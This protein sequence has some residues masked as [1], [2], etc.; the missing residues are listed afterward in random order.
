VE[1]LLDTVD[2]D[3]GMILFFVVVM[4]VVEKKMIFL[5]CVD[6]DECR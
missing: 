5:D 4:I 3:G 6:D 1:T 2:V